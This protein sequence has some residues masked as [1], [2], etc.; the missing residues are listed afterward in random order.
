MG[1]ELSERSERSHEASEAALS[2]SSGF[3]SKSTTYE[4]SFCEWFFICT[5]FDT[6]LLGFWVL[7]F[8][9]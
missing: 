9:F 2:N 4:L 7:N 8:G 1:F 5:Q 6:Q 3:T